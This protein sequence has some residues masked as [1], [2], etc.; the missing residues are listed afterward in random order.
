M[1][2]FSSLLLALSACL[3]A[4]PLSAQGVVLDEGQFDVSIRGVRVGTEDFSIRRAGFGSD[5]TIFA[6]AMISLATPEGSQQIRPLLAAMPPDGVAASYQVE[7]AGPDA[8]EIQLRLTGRRYAAIIHSAAGEEDREF[9][10]R[11]DTRILERSVA[12]HYYFLRDLREGATASV[13]EPR[14]RGQTSLR[15]GAWTEVELRLG[16]NRVEARRVEFTSG[17]DRRIVWFDRQG[18]VLRV[19]VP[20]LGYVAERSDLVG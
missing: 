7:V 15:A 8:V 18:R 19:E 4:V 9:R 14:T 13:I 6:N 16:R 10:A 5:G 3:V 17:A 2:T 20:A 1:N 11:P 12:H